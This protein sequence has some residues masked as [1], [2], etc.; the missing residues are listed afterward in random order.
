MHIELIL[1]EPSA[2]AFFQGFLPR[3]LP[4]GVTWNPIVFQ[5]KADLLLQIEKRLKG[6]SSWIPEDWRIVVLVDEDR[7]DCRVLKQKLENAARAAGL[8]TKSSPKCGRF[9][10][11]NRIAV[12][13]LEAWFLGDPAALSSTFEGVSPHFGTKA[14]YRDPDAIAGGTWEALERLLQKSGYYP[15]GLAK[16]EVARTLSTRIDPST[17]KSR[18]FRCFVEGISALFTRGAQ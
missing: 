12:E 17:N 16:M 1:E 9:T 3:I 2:E 7:G 5:G 10:V 13:E 15:S 8:S 4:E 11:L 18:S 6:Y 14:G